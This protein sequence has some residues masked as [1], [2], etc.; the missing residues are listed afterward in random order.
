MN[1]PPK[2]SVK[3]VI[4]VKGPKEREILRNSA[5]YITSLAKVESIDFVSGI[6]KPKSSATYVFGDIQ[7]H[8][9]L[10]GLIN[11]ED[12]RRRMRKEIKKIERAPPSIVE[13]VKEK[14]DLIGLKLEK[15]N[16]NL[17]ILEGL[18]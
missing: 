9:L 13:G 8:V 4:D 11:Y 6:E 17:T 2:T 16:Q 15:L 5:T 3:T 18:K 10:E 14:V 7:V 1:I 12:E